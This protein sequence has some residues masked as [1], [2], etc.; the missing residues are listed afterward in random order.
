MISRVCSPEKGEPV[1]AN[2]AHWCTNDGYGQVRYKLKGN[3]QVL[4]LT[5]SAI[6]AVYTRVLLPQH[7]SCFS[8]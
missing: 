2:V 7:P 3:G 8:H 5:C 4:T 1:P 6:V